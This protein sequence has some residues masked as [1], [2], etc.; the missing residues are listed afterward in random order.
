MESA[1]RAEVDD[2]CA[3]NEIIPLDH[4]PGKGYPPGDSLETY[5]QDVRQVTHKVGASQESQE[6][7]KPAIKTIRHLWGMQ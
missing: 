2:R 1:P 3:V 6:A 5:G 7:V 4:L